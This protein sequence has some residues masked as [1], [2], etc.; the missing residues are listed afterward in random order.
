MSEMEWEGAPE[1]YV[2]RVRNWLSPAVQ[3]VANAMYGRRGRFYIFW[4]P[5][6]F[7]VLYWWLIKFCIFAMIV[8]GLLAVFC[9]WAIAE[10]ITY[11]HR[12]RSAALRDWAPY[13]GEILD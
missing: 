5:F 10:C 13:M 9:V 6:I 12:V 8:A 1:V 7:F 3:G 2:P 4:W 11:R